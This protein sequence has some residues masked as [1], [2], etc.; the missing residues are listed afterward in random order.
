MFVKKELTFMSATDE[1]ELERKNPTHEAI[2]LFWEELP[3]R[4]RPI[5]Y[6]EKL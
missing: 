5:N 3:L 4:V 6:C 2:S 1:K